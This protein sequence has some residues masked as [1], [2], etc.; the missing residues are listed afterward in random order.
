VIEVETASGN[1]ITIQQNRR[2]LRRI[3]ESQKGYL[4]D[5]D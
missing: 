2:K 3:L 1:P 5:P 4:P